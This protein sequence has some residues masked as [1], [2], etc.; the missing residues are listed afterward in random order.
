M[1]GDPEP[2]TVAA[3]PP[4]TPRAAIAAEHAA[5]VAA[6]PEKLRPRCAPVPP[7]PTAKAALDDWTRE[8]Q[9]IYLFYLIGA[10]ARGIYRD[11]SLA[12]VPFVL[13]KLGGLAGEW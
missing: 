8:T 3:P 7:M 4:S 11:S 2:A 10:I 5:G 6:L 12:N 9:R 1:F 13:Q